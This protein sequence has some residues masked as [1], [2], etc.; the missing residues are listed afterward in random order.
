MIFFPGALKLSVQTQKTWRPRVV[1]EY[2]SVDRPGNRA[3][4]KKKPET[5]FLFDHDASLIVNPKVSTGMN[6]I[7]P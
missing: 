2:L 5:V 7:I 6:A 4:Q 3:V 1:S